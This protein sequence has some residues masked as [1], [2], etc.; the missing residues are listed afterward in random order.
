MNYS[1]TAPAE[2]TALLSKGATV[3]DVRTPAEYRAAH[4]VGAQLMPLDALDAEAF[5]AQ[6]PADEPTYILCQSGKRACTAADRLSA[7]GMSQLHVIEG[8]TAAAESAGVEM[9]YGKSTISIERQV[10]IAAGGLVVLGTLLG[11][12][13][14]GG[15][16]ILPAFI[17][18]G[19]VFAGVTDTCG[20]AMMLGKCPWNQ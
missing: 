19:L 7:A 14:H 11:L 16:F 3:I 1:K 20:M 15:F 17:G 2:L 9:A 5:K 12:F 6:H 18:A 13:V 10:R 8:G 4:V